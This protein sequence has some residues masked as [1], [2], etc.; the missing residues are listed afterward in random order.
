MGK[1]N[2]R[3]ALHPVDLDG[4]VERQL[5]LRIFRAREAAHIEACQF[6]NFDA[7]HISHIA[8]G[9]AASWLFKRPVSADEL[10]QIVEIL[11]WLYRA[12]AGLERLEGRR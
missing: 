11:G 2:D 12:A 4:P 3:T 9:I 5:R 6:Q 1:P 7:G 10:E 8:A